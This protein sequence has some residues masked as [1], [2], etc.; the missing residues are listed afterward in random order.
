M[1]DLWRP[2]KYNTARAREVIDQLWFIEDCENT[3]RVSPFRPD[4]PEPLCRRFAYGYALDGSEFPCYLVWPQRDERSY[5]LLDTATSDT[6]VL[7]EKSSF[8]P[9]GMQH[10]YDSFA[11][12]SQICIRRDALELFGLYDDELLPDLHITR[13]GVLRAELGAHQEHLVDQDAHAAD[14]KKVPAAVI[15]VASHEVDT[16]SGKDEAIIATSDSEESDS[17]SES[18]Q[19]EPASSLAS[20]SEQYEL[21]QAAYT[22]VGR[23][24][25]DKVAFI[26]SEYHKLR[27]LELV[28]QRWP[29]CKTFHSPAKECGS[30]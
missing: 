10:F 8:R 30:P 5:V 13:A 4:G 9:L 14:R 15:H 6:L 12:V 23:D 25:T 22:E 7:D 16:D 20:D 29:L 21:M 28:P 3:R 19:N 17:A 24:F 26:G 1:V 2:W 27:R 18:E 11:L